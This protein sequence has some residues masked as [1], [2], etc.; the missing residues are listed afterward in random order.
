[1]H[2]PAAIK[3]PALKLLPNVL[4]AP[5]V[6]PDQPTAHLMNHRLHRRGAPFQGRF[7][8]ACYICIS[9][10][11]HEQPSWAHMNGFKPR[12][13]HAATSVTR[14]EV[15][16]LWLDRPKLCHFEARCR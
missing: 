13:F 9:M 12:D 3:S 2:R 14:R 8:P 5:G 11:A 1:M 7:A 10:D 15:G 4:D 16:G 6:P